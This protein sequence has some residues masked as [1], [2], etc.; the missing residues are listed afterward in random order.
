[1]GQEVNYV[2]VKSEK[3]KKTAL[4]LCCLGFFCFAGL[5]YFYVGRIGKG[6]LYLFTLG[7]FLIGTIADVF[8]IAGGGFV[9]S[10]GA[11]LRK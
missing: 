8:K 4:I 1:M 2:T 11:P 6:L 7:F 9:D 5:H 3:S 10:A